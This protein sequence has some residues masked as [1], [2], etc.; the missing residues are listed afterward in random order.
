[1]NLLVNAAQAIEE[2]GTITV[3]TRY[4]NGN[5]ASNHTEQNYVEVKI[6]DTGKGIPEDKLDRIFE[7]FFTTK[8]VGKGTGLGLSIAYD[9][10]RKHQGEITVQSEVGNGT[11]FL[12]ILPVVD[13]P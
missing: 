8:D 2:K 3:S 7:P 13:H 6:S 5:L 9:I 12:I 11:T 4:V 10:I 1:M